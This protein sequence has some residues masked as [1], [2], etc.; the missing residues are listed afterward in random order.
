VV[1]VEAVAGRRTI[2]LLSICQFLMSSVL[3]AFA[4][5]LPV[6]LATMPAA[7]FLAAAV[8]APFW[9]RV[10][11]RVGPKWMLIRAGAAE[12]IFTAL[13]AFA[14]APWELLALRIGLGLLAGYAVAATAMVSLISPRKRLG[15]AMG[16]LAAGQSAGIT[17]APLIGE[18][19]WAWFRQAAS[20]LL[21]ISAVAAAAL[22]LTLVAIPHLTPPHPTI[23]RNTSRSRPFAM[24]RP[25]GLLA[26]L[27]LGAQ[28]A[29]TAVVPLATAWTA[30][31]RGVPLQQ[32]VGGAAA[33]LAIS[34]VTGALCSSLAGRLIDAMGP[35]RT[36]IFA[37]FGAAA[38]LGIQA[39]AKS[40][41]LFFGARAVLGVFTSAIFPA[42]N[43]IVALTSS[44]RERGAA[45]GVT[46]GAIFLGNATGPVAGGLLAG[47]LGVP[48]V[49]GLAAGW[50]MALG[51]G[52]WLGALVAVRGRSPF[53]QLVR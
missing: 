46:T 50:L 14:T 16:A 24:V 12:T 15:A 3:W 53:N 37:F 1:R 22:V 21:A 48:G 45:Y 7:N 26:I 29:L 38:C 18:L 42:I 30:H 51:A 4:P 34:G 47:L 40:Y 11:D 23:G 43:A 39:M 25:Y 41:G 17:V 36:L 13:M 20:A 5:I 35:R 52:S 27:A 2:W 44:G 33:L 9:G 8:M 32:A 31:L 19:F 28:A 6:D 49:L 10:T